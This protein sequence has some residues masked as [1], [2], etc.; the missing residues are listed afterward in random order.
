MPT[1]IYNNNVFIHIPKTGGTSISSL[2]Q[3][4]CF[5]INKYINDYIDIDKYLLIHSPIYLVNKKENNLINKIAFVRNPYT[6]FI[7]IFCMSKNLGIHNYDITIEGISQFCEDFKKSNLINHLIFKPMTYYICDENLNIIVDYIFKYENFNEE[8]IK[9]CEIMKI[10]IPNNIPNINN[11][12]YIDKKD[13]NNFYN[14]NIYNFVNE[15][16]NDDFEKFNY[17]KNYSYP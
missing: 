15:I 9:Y 12:L 5:F 14:L 1:L 13:Y 17:I 7:S 11:N 2:T 6:R 10:N 8:I 3:Q 16:Y 4:S